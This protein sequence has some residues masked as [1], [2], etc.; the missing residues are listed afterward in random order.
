MHTFTNSMLAFCRLFKYVDGKRSKIYSKQRWLY[1]ANDDWRTSGL[2][3][4]QPR[5]SANQIR[6]TSPARE[7]EK[8]KEEECLKFWEISSLYVSILGMSLPWFRSKD[9]PTHANYIICTAFVQVKDV[10]LFLLTKYKIY[11]PTA[12]F[13]I[14]ANVDSSRL[15]M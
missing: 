11:F 1:T 3:P 5:K 10:C 8:S 6:L 9:W 14:H 12:L 2:H 7:E 15:Y 13:M 4:G